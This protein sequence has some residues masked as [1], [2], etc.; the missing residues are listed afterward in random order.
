[1]KK[2]IYH[3]PSTVYRGVQ[4]LLQSVFSS[5]FYLLPST[6]FSRGFTL[7]ETLVAIT[8]LLLSLSG[9]LSIAA[10]SMYVA[11]YSR[12][13]ITAFYLAQEGIEY[14]RA[15]RDRQFLA[16]GNSWG[17]TVSALSTCA[18]NGC[19]IDFPEFRHEA[20]PG[21]ACE[22]LRRSPSGVYNHFMA[23]SPNTP[24]MYTRRVIVTPMSINGSQDALLVRVI[25]S[26]ASG[27]NNRSIELR[28]F[29]F[30]YNWL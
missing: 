21:G 11:Q 25:M 3:L 9:P 14:V 15:V 5:T 29:L 20:C 22:A 19:R 4:K 28:T 7:I 27:R 16:G 26:W 8:V 1:M 30:N 13:Q 10:Q 6:N 24:S 12:E 17:N 23:A 18:G 2:Q